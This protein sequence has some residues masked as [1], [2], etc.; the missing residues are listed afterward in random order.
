MN[1][2]IYTPKQNYK[3][4]VRCFT[5]NQSNYIEDALNGFTLQKT[6]FPFVCLVM[7]DCSTDGEQDV[8]KAW[9]ERECN[10][11]KVEYVNEGIADII[12]VPHKK[13]ENCNFAIYFLKKNLYKNPFKMQIVAPWREHCE[14]EATC[15]GDDIWTTDDKLQKSCVF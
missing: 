10:M 13:N 3:V 14:Y 15:E 6:T 5:Y 7:D 12:I 4:L 11:T 9:M 8:I 1:N 2:Q